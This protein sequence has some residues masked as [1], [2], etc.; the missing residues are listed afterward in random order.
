M[1]NNHS[2]LF[3]TRYSVAKHWAIRVVIYNTNTQL[4]DLC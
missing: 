4:D 1:I 3:F 2:S